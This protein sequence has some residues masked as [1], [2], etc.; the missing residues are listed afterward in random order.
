[1][2]MELLSDFLNLDGLKVLYYKHFEKHTEI[3]VEVERTEQICPRCSKTTNWIQSH[4]TQ[5]IRDVNFGDKKTYLILHKK[6]YRCKHCGKTFMEENKVLNCYQRMTTRLVNEI[7]LKLESECS[8]TSVAKDYDISVNTVIRLFDRLNYPEASLK[9]VEVLS[10]DEFKG[11]TGGEKYNCIITCPKTK[12]VLDILPSR[13]YNDLSGY[14]KK[15]NREDIKY[16]VSDMWQ[17]YKELAKAFFKNAMFIVDKYHWIRQVIWAFENVRKQE[18]KKFYKKYRRYFKKS[19]SL[20]TKRFE[21]LTDEEKRQVN[22]MLYKSD[23]IFIAHSLKEEF[24]ELLDI[25]NSTEAI[26]LMSKWIV[27][28]QKSGLKPFEKCANT[29]IKWSKGI[30]NSF[31]E[32]YTNGFTEGCNNKIKVL[33]RNAYGYRNFKRFRNRILHMFA[34]KTRV[35]NNN[36]E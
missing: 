25:E 27:S 2:E 33:K 26:R 9:G 3:N 28:A 22:I 31:E 15:K 34:Y 36:V 29:I 17:P 30:L 1:M 5:K 4:R 19:K 32:A 12:Q 20:L 21:F 7:L 35:A 13:K 8:F 6:R 18:Q 14:F 16:F 24:L 23:N 10:I 11:N